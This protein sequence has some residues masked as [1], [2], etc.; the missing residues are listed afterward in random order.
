MNAF[1]VVGAIVGFVFGGLVLGGLVSLVLDGLQHYIK[2]LKILT[3][4]G[5]KV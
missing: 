3:I 2:L 1:L 4:K 5:L